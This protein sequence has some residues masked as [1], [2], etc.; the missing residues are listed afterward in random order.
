MKGKTTGIQLV[1]FAA[2]VPYLHN[3]GN[4]SFNVFYGIQYFPTI[5]GVFNQNQEVNK[6]FANL[7]LDINGPGMFI[8]FLRTNVPNSFSYVPMN[9][10]KK[11]ENKYSL[12]ILRDM[13]SY[14]NPGNQDTFRSTLI[15][16]KRIY[17]LYLLF[18]LVG[19]PGNMGK[20]FELKAIYNLVADTVNQK[21]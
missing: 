2:G 10:V 8:Y 7:V 12:T 5:I 18:R 21:K 1:T 9:L 16:G 6:V 20:Y 3:T 15:D 4:T 11:I 19:D 17:N 14:R 13:A